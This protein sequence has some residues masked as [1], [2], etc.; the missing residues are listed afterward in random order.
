[1]SE[2]FVTAIKQLSKEK[3]L[4]PDTVF[5]AVEAAM[6]SAFKKD[7]LQYA[8]LEVEIDKE[9]GEIKITRI[10]QVI[11]DD[12]IEDDEIEVSPERAIE[13]GHKKAKIGEDIKEKIKTTKNLGR[14]AAQTT[15]QVVL[16]RIRE[17][18]RNSVHDEFSQQVGELVS[19]TVI[20]ID[21]SKNIIVDIGKAEGLIPQSEQIRSEHYRSGQRVK[22]YI[23]DVNK[24]G[25]GPQIILSRKSENLIE[26]LFE[27]EVPEL[28]KGIVKIMKVARS[29]GRRT[30]VA[31]IATQVGIDPIGSIIGMRGSRIQNI[32]NDLNG[33]RIDLIRWDS[34]IAAFITSALSPAEIV[35]INIDESTKT[36]FIA[37]PDKQLSLAIGRNGENATLAA[38]LTG[39]TIDLQ[40][41][42]ALINSGEDLIPPPEPNLAE[43]LEQS[44]IQDLEKSINQ[45]IVE[46]S[47]KDDSSTDVSEIKLTP[48][49]EIIQ[50]YTIAANQANQAEGIAPEE[51]Q[52]ANQDIQEDTKG[53]R[54][55]EEIRDVDR[56]VDK[57]LKSKKKRSS[58]KD[59]VEDD[60]EY[61]EYADLFKED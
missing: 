58:R 7:E 18:E 56:G 22:L 23:K 29:A 26:K 54:F 9:T 37:V 57:K 32:I 21:P 1:M 43:I 52:D 27:I 41:E 38:K 14:I 4:D 46:E 44:Q 45:E 28:N 6:A 13:M 5:S 2:N 25:R 48:E 20:R 39:Y 15:K 33:E 51:T 16:Q 10:Y 3:N 40:A 30:K 12:D 11:N 53:I 50:E 49:Q 55:A 31:V 42:S 59:I 34:N 47:A 61:A 19:G 8:N 24:M 60:D 36:A 35:S 17:A